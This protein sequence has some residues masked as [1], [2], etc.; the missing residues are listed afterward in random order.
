MKNILLL[1]L[2][3]S[4]AFC[5]Y[6]Q[7]QQGLPTTS[8][9]MLQM[10]DQLLEERHVLTSIRRAKADSVSN[11]IRRTSDP[12]AIKRHY[13]DLTDLYSELST[14][15]TIAACERGYLLSRETDDSVMAQKF[16]I[17]RARA[18]FYAGAIHDGL[19]DLK[20][21]E[22]EGVYPENELLYHRNSCI[23][24][25]TLGAFLDF[26][27][28]SD[29]SLA[30]GLK[31]ALRWAEL[32]EPDS[33]QYY[34]AQG[35]ADMCDRKPQLMAAN[36]HD[37]LK[38]A[39]IYDFEFNRAAVILGEYYRT[40]GKYDDAIYHYALAAA[41]NVY[42]ANLEGVA[43]LRLGET[44]YETGDI[45]RANKYMAHSLE[46][47]VV[48]GQNFN[49]M[50]INGAYMEVGNEIKER[51][52]HQL[53]LLVACVLVF[54]AL[55]I[56][57]IKMIFDKRRQLHKMKKTEFLLARANMAKETYISEFMNLSSSYIELLEEYNKTCRRKLTA[58]QVD[59][60]MTFLKSDKV[61]ENVRRKFY[62]VFD[63][64]LRHIYPDFVEQVNNLLQP[65]KKITTEPGKLNTELRVAAMSRLGIEDASVIARFLGISTNTIYT[66]RN[67]LR[68]RAINRSTIEED[69]RH[70]GMVDTD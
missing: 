44:L 67:K 18:Y 62:D 26:R 59:D 13:L 38:K 57:V 14:D 22:N 25:V 23:M 1:A 64:A 68:T 20:Q 55:L 8:K 56:I 39:S 19:R 30:T 53:F 9:G 2:A 29:E 28:V 60:L 16:L 24:Y 66:Y 27:N 3:C 12:E 36:L 37:C 58:G 43:L 15:S 4:F 46:K 6:A 45:V 34:L 65:D 21:V 69:I 61:F 47:A 7:T 17:M 11:I 10:L 51:R 48:G 49:L 33:P 5:S 31:H 40:T 35:I 42:N 63:E 41:S 50:L 54:V 32:S 70:I 52:D